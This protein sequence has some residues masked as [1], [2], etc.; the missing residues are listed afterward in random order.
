MTDTKQI[1]W[2][3]IEAAA[4]EM[5]GNWQRRPNFVW[6][7][8]S[9]LDYADNWCIWYTSNRDAGLLEQSNEAEIN[10][11]LKP[12]SEGNDPDLVFEQHS[13]WACGYLD[14]FSIRVYRADG[15]ITPAFEEFCRIKQDLEDYPVLNEDDYSQ[16]EY[17]A[18]LEN[19]ACEMWNVKDLP[20]VRSDAP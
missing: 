6:F 20:D 7:R 2:S 14:G 19:Y 12:F 3:D 13:H 16:R 9:R 17:E 18:T 1:D 10:K 15:S 11:R 4:K 5:A 8:G